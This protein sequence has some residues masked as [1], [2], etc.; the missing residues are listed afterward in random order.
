MLNI[1]DLAHKSGASEATVVRMCK[2]LGYDGYYQMRLIMSRDAGKVKS[3]TAGNEILTSADQI[4][5][6]S[7]VRI[8]HLSEG[9]STETLLQAARI[10]LDANVIHIISVGNSIPIA[11][12][13]GFRLERNGQNCTYSMLPEHFFNH[14]SLGSNKDVVVAITRSG[15][16]TQVI[17]ATELAHKKKMKIV[18]ITSELNKQLIGNADCIIR[19]VD[20]KMPCFE[21]MRPDSHLLEMAINDALLYAVK[22]YSKITRNIN[23]GDDDVTTNDV[24][25]LLSQFKL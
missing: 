18:V 22:N 4:F 9:I 5:V 13:L 12:D 16:S 21:M 17:R 6:N 14:I 7:S 25:L 3:T 1:S 23:S 10:L 11:M 15:S 8:E 2:H 20:K 24:D 19:I